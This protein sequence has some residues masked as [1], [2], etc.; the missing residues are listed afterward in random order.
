MKYIDNTLTSII[1]R[2]PFNLFRSNGK[3]DIIKRSAW[4]ESQINDADALLQKMPENLNE[5]FKGEW[6]IYSCAMYVAALS[7]IARQ[8]PELCNFPLMEKVIDIML[9]PSI[10]AYD[11]NQWGSDALKTLDKTDKSHMTYLSL[12]AWAMSNYKLAGGTN[13]YDMTLHNCCDALNRRII[14]SPQFNLPSYPDGTVYFPDMLVAIVALHN[15][16]LLF[17][18]RYAET[19]KTWISRARGEWVDPQTGLLPHILGSTSVRG[20]YTALSCYYLSLIDADFAKDQYDRMKKY[21]Q[22]TL[23]I[24]EFADSSPKYMFDVDAGPIILGVS[25]SGTAF[26][27]GSAT[28]FN[29]KYLKTKLLTIADVF[30]GTT[31][32]KNTR[33]YIL[34][35]YAFVGE[36]V[37]LAMKTNKRK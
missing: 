4:I 8:Y 10:R 9:S 24:K 6:A 12:L 17:G 22:T 18:G 16:S 30:G 14:N 35:E 26:A 21:L 31:S 20:S 1:I 29:D 11:T 13:K 34:A 2:M 23:G 15:F 5:H 25:P 19:V 37:M 27:V 7:N 28:F 3:K 32:N 33:H 36:C